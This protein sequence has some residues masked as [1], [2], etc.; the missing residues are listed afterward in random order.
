M[1]AIDGRRVRAGLGK[2]SLKHLSKTRRRVAYL[3][4]AILV[5]TIILTPLA[6][7]GASTYQV[8]S[9]IRQL[10]DDGVHQLLNIKDL[11]LKSTS[12]TSSCATTTPSANPTSTPATVTPSATAT[13]GTGLTLPGSLSG[14]SLSS[15]NLKAFTDK[16]TLNQ[17]YTDFVAA[18]SDFVQLDTELNNHPTLLSLA[19]LI[20][21]YAKQANEARMVAQAGIDLATLGAEATTTALTIVQKLPANPLSAGNTPLF[22]NDEIPLIQSTINDADQLLG[23]LQTQLAGIDPNDLPITT[24]QRHTLAKAISLLP[25]V[26]KVLDQVNNLLPVGVWMLGI[27]Q[28]RKFL[29]Q[30][31]D[32]AELRGSGGFTG[33]YGV[34]TINGGRIGPLALQDIAFLDY[35]GT[36]TGYA[37]GNH[38]PA[39]WSWWPFANWGLRDSNISAD[40]PTTAQVAINLFAKE[41]GGHVDGVISLTPIPI[42]HILAITGPIVI[43]EYG[44]TITSQNLEDRIHYYQQDPAGI[45]KEK[46]I[47]GGNGS[48]TVRK[49]FTS[50]VGKLLEERLRQ[51]PLDQLILVAKQVF[52]DMRSKDLEV[53]LSDPRAE[54]LLTKYGMDASIDR[55]GSTDTWMLVQSNISVSKATQYVQTTQKDV[56][57]LDAS[58]GATHHLTITLN[59]NKQGNVYGYP[60]YR[61]YVRIYAPAGSRLISG[62]GFDSGS[63]MCLA[64]PPSGWKA[65]KPPANPQPSKY[66]KLPQCSYYDPYPAGGLSCPAGGW[67]T[68]APYSFSYVDPADGKTPWPIDYLSGPRNTSSDEPGLTM[69]G[70]LVMIPPHCTATITLVWYTPKVAAPGKPVQTGQPPYSLLVQRQSGT[71]NTLQVTIKPASGAAKVQ[72]AKQATFKGTLGANQ[73]ISLPS[74]TCN[75][76][77][78]CT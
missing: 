74:P 36:G 55:S 66:A 75:G 60:T 3:L 5:L 34:V 12:N 54:A 49:R 1:Q 23:N 70:G 45:A 63:P 53:Y 25:D 35:A 43:P 64:S 47:S 27:D 57:Q 48:I 21:G 9:H 22:T 67:A 39:K 69:W 71:F 72:G 65:P 10:G 68:G 16:T 15:L 37:I 40:Y 6:M 44:E 28:P 62:Y 2:L 77:Q 17:A 78:H 19:S 31:M 30:T 42:E 50:L 7:A 18:K 46:R 26:H 24:C 32:R 20:P 33:Q 38:P 61:D 56:V 14:F 4:M 13:S 58:G 51:L 59:Y 29:I 76:S 41:G 52:A 8:Y 73:L 11:F